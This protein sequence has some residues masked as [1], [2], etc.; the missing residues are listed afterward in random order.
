MV[1]N[2]MEAGALLQEIYTT[3]AQGTGFQIF[4]LNNSNISNAI[5]NAIETVNQTQRFQQYYQVEQMLLDNYTTI[6]ACDFYFIQDYYS[7]IIYWPAAHGRAPPLLGY[8][9]YFRDFEFN[10]TAMPS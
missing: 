1:P 5:W 7:N 9:Y 10:V 4:W 8:Q 3:Q 6:Y 2:Y